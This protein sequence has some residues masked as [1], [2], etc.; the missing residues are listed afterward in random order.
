MAAQQRE[1]EE[2]ELKVPESIPLCSQTLPVT[3][4]PPPPL[5]T[6]VTRSPEISDLNL[7]SSNESRSSSG[8]LPEM[9]DLKFFSTDE[10]RSS[11]GSTPE[12]IDLK[13]SSGSSPDSIDLKFSGIDESRFSSGI[14]PESIDLKSRKSGVKSQR[15]VN[16]C[17]GIGCRRKVGLMSFRCRCGEV[18]CSEHRYSDRHDCSYDYKAAGRDAIARENPVVKA[19]KILK[20]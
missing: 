12:K 14:S 17:S 15:E 11:S 7:S 8:N 3:A 13:L 10:S 4:P 19:A 9:I 2:T 16:R 6:A 1:K 5:H 18:F 20:V